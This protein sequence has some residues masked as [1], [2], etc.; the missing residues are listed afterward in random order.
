MQ[1]NH[2]TIY[3][4]FLGVNMVYKHMLFYQYALH[5]FYEFSLC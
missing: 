3:N 4:V 5:V 2:C 1:L